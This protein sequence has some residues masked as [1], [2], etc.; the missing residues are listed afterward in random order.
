MIQ[1]WQQFNEGKKVKPNKIS[2]KQSELTD[3]MLDKWIEK[4]RKKFGDVHDK[5][6]PNFMNL[7]SFGIRALDD[8]NTDTKSKEK[9][10]QRLLEFYENDLAHQER[11]LCDRCGNPMEVYYTVH[12][13]KCEKPEPKDNELNYLLCVNWLD[14]NEEEFDKDDLWRYL[15]D[16]EVIQG[17]DTYCTLPT[18]SKDENM[19]IFMKHFDTRKTKYFVSW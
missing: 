12:C 19:N 8:P 13:F 15:L 18:S 5:N 14:K 2:Y 6:N 9:W 10:K 11:L 7:I 17:N 4:C 1:N 3:E 16:R